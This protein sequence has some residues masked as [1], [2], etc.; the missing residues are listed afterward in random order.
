M[1]LEISLE[2][3]MSLNLFFTQNNFFTKSMFY[4]RGDP[5]KYLPDILGQKL[6]F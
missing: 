3:D 6:L 5:G 1:G 4:T 2:Y